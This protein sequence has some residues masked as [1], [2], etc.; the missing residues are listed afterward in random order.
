MST[1]ILSACRVQPPRT[2]ARRKIRQPVAFVRV[3][4]ECEPE[5]SER[6]PEVVVAQRVRELRR[7]RGWTQDDLAREM[8]ARG[9]PMHQTTIAKLETQVRPIRLNEAATL[10]AIFEVSIHDLVAEPVPP[11]D[12]QELADAAQRV[13]ELRVHIGELTA[14]V[15]QAEARSALALA[16]VAAVR[17]RREAAAAE[18]DA[19]VKMLKQSWVT[20]SAS[21][22]EGLSVVATDTAG[23][24]DGGERQ[25]AT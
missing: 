19:L 5:S 2:S 23:G 7:S 17:Q 10:A 22:G 21:P 9:W 1:W 20:V 15:G 24:E 11:W 4:N 12:D 18:L 6:G 13:Q 14:Q 16:V 8:A 25:A 3:G